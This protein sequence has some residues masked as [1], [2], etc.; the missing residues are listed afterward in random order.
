MPSKDITLA[1][2]TGVFDARSPADL[3]PTGSVRMRQN[4]QTVGEGKLRRGSGFAKLLTQASY[5]NSDFHDQLLTFGATIRQPVTLITEAESSAKVR[6]LFIAT[7]GRIARLSEHGGNWKILGSGFGGAASASATAPRF[8]SARVGD[9]LAFTND[10]DRPKYHILEQVGVSGESLYE[11][12]DFV[13]IGLRRAKLVWSWR[14]F[15][16]VANVEMDGK[17]YANRLLGSDFDN[18]TSF[19][20]AKAESITWQK[21]LMSHEEILGGAPLANSFLIYTTHGIWEMTVVGGA[22]TMGFRR[23]Y[24][25]EDNKMLRL[26]KYPNTLVNSG[27]AHFYAADETKEE[28][29]G[30]LYTFSQY[31]GKP[32][33]LDWLHASTPVIFQN[34]NKTA[35]ESH[36]AG[37]HG[38]EIL[39]F[40]AQNG[41]ANECP[42]VGLRIN[43]KYRAAD[44]LDFGV[45]ALGNFSNQN[46]QTLRDFIIENRICTLSGLSALGYGYTNEGLPNPLPVGTA[47]F[48]P[49]SI[50]TLAKLEFGGTLTVASAG[51]AAANGT[52]VF[53]YATNRYVKA[54]NSYYI[55]TSTNGTTRSWKLFTNAD[56]LLYTN[57]ATVGGTWATTNGGANPKP[58]VTKGADVITTEDYEK[59]ANDSDSLCAL[60]GSE[61]VE[62]GCRGCDGGTLFVATHS[63]DWCLKQLGDVYYREECANPTATGTTDSNGYN[64]AA[65]SYILG[66][67]ESIWRSAPLFVPDGGIITEGLSMQFLARAQTPPSN[68]GLRIGISGQIA[69]PNLDGCIVWHQHSLKPLKC[70]SE[71]TEAEHLAGNTQPA[72]ALSWVFVRQGPNLYFELKITGTGGDADFSRLQVKA[73]K[74]DIH[75]Y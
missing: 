61:T 32:E 75:N 40:T 59:T 63:D 22:E 21:D 65:G 68:I 17:R 34:I 7:Q 15:L 42:S 52:Y 48:E 49:M 20:P 53:N 41:D 44:K 18:P 57:T 58:A 67:I 45:A 29:N 9:Y 24:N 37:I 27:D 47:A 50:H 33:R 51:T 12:E 31:Y 46:V 66:G 16:I 73:H 38:N 26:L 74:Y 6:S 36:V 25:G 60:L 3:M 13:T 10:W 72:T 35:C 4:M 64:S 5:N 39:I 62:A 54:A 71:R 11:F 28:G 1:P 19:D 69:D 56:V 2:L 23:I 30:G 8:K 55:V 43:M 70:Q 14:N